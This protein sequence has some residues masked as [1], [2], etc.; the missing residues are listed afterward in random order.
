MLSRRPRVFDLLSTTPPRL[1]RVTSREGERT[2]NARA[3]GA[4]PAAPNPRAT[5]RRSG[6]TRRGLVISGAN[7]GGKSV[8][9]K[10][11]GL[12]AALVRLGAPIPCK[13]E[14]TIGVFDPVFADVGDAQ[15]AEG[16]VSTYVGHLR[17]AA[18]AVAEARS[19]ATLTPL[20]L[21]GR[22][23]LGHGRGPGRGVG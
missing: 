23:R 7:A 11:L 19:S 1:G 16:N 21:L 2:S 5:T 8:W 22:A 10:T 9:L 17:V 18:A 15:S 3:R 13:G 12:C 6:R 14:P 20:V 4:P